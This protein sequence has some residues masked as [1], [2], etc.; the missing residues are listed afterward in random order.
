[1]YRNFWR[2]RG[3]SGRSSQRRF[4]SGGS[5]GYLVRNGSLAETVATWHGRHW[6]SHW[7][8]LHVCAEQKFQAIRYRS[9]KFPQLFDAWHSPQLR[10]LCPLA[11]RF[12]S[13]KGTI[14]FPFSSF[15]RSQ[16]INVFFFVLC[17]N[18]LVVWEYHS[19][20]ATWPFGEQWH[21]S[22]EQ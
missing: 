6:K 13:F 1:M 8:F 2:C 18:R 21:T 14:L 4:R 10:R 11:G 5:S 12:R 16:A 7:R 20:L 17:V 19:L 22:H 9:R 3:P 15:V